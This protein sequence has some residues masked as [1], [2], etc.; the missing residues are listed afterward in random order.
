MGPTGAGKTRMVA[1]VPSRGLMGY[2]GEFL[3]NT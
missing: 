1:H 3:T 2:H